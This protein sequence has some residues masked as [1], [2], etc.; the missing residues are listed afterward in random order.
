VTRDDWSSG[1]V[2]FERVGPRTVLRAARAE[3]PL[4]LL[5]PVNHGDGAWVFVASLGGGLVDGDSVRL[6]LDVGPGAVGLL[7]TQASTKVYRCPT[8]TCRMDLRARVAEGGMLVLLPD[9]VVCF[10]GARYDQRVHVEL[11]PGATLVAVDTFTAGRSARGERWDF[12]RYASRSVIERE[13]APLWV[14][15]ITLDPVHGNLGA[16]MGRV[17]AFATLVV[18]GPGAATLRTAVVERE[19]LRAVPHG[20]RA[21]S[22]ERAALVV[23]SSPVQG[24]GVMLRVAGTSTEQVTA[25]VREHL[26]G[27]G[28]LLGDDPFARKW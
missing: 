11:S 3:S 25:C 7:G 20:V 22:E 23:S 5:T 17:D 24:D 1:T 6:E 12:L 16:R 15:A 13:G 18:T 26:R 27:L 2:A 19:A 8:R 21:A 28:A 4:R 9:P 14:D 10:A